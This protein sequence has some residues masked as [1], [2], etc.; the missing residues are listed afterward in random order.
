MIKHTTDGVSFPL[1]ATSRDGG[2][3]FSV[4]TK[5][6][7]AVE[8]LLFDHAD[9]GVPARII[10]FDP[11]LN[12]T[13]YYWHRFVP[14]LGAGQLYGYRVYGPFEPEN[15]FRFDGEKLLID[16]YARCVDVGTRYS[17]MAASK[18]GSNLSQA[19]KS[20]VVDPASFDWEDDQ[21][22][23]RPYSR[24]IIYE[25]HVGGFTRHPNSGVPEPKR[26]TY[27]GL[28]E[29]IPYLVDLGITAVELMPVQQFDEQ[30][31]PSSLKNYWGYSPIAFFA[32]HAAY[33]SDRSA[34]GPVNEFREMVK[35]LHR[36]G[37]EVIL[38]VV[39]NHTAEGGED[40]PTLAFR[41]CENL[42]YYILNSSKRGDEN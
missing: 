1:G 30:D 34:L 33:S 10:P 32:P 5:Y 27:A 7:T 3:N 14:G 2:V 36:A 42:A 4:F 6:A 20:V 16:P 40:G 28:I 15:G 23:R 13:Y 26:G 22:L 39:F 29:K 11:D 17:R 35:A 21:P 18:P 25:L 8:L 19:M 31:V 9:D 38:D 37:I 41:G 12:R 24:T